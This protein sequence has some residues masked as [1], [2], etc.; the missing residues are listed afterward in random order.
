M[1]LC[2]CFF[3]EFYEHLKQKHGIVGCWLFPTLKKT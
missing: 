1:M 3:F 2:R